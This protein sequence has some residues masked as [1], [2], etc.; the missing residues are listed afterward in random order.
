M[1][2]TRSFAV[3]AV[4]GLAAF[5]L[6]GCGGD[7]PSQADAESQACEAVASVR[8]AL[9][10]VAGLDAEST[11]EQAQDARQTLDDAIAGLRDA[12]DD[13][14]AADQAA[15]QAGGQA[16]STAIDGVSGSDTIGAAGEAVAQASDTLRGAVGEIADGLGCS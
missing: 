8:D 7:T 15:L 10:G 9:E 16:I 5:G 4:S 2:L 3:V 13:L 11:V 1:S 14:Q 6:S 12:A